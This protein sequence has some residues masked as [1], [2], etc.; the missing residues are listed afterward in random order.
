MAKGKLKISVSYYIRNQSESS[1][2]GDWGGWVNSSRACLRILGRAITFLNNIEKKERP[3]PRFHIQIS[4]LI[5]QN[6][7][8][9]G[10]PYIG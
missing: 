7:V 4:V 9:K 3:D 2:L 1:P 10:P 6:N 8:C 5:F